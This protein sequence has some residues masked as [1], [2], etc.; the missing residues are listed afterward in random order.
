MK[1]TNTNA[2]QPPESNI[3]VCSFHQWRHA[4][5]TIH[6]CQGDISLNRVTL[7]QKLQETISL[8]SSV[9]K[10]RS[11]RS[12]FCQEQFHF[13]SL[14]D[15]KELQEEYLILAYDHLLTIIMDTSKSDSSR[16][17]LIIV[18]VNKQSLPSHVKNISTA[19]GFLISLLNKR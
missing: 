18:S 3:D 5:F 13:P 2:C 4:H 17:D 9:S 14:S 16:S 8:C 1:R 10:D 11:E 19:F 12:I 7:S 6:K 15:I